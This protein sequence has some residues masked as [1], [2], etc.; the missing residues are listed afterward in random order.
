MA[1]ELLMRQDYL[2]QVVFPEDLCMYVSVCQCIPLIRLNFIL[3]L[4]CFRQIKNF[5]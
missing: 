3:F 2:L 5:K 4:T 1:E